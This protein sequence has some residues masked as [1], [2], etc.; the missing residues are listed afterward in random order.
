VLL[1]ISLKQTDI[2]V[3][4]ILICKNHHRVT[5]LTSNDV[6]YGSHESVMLDTSNMV[7]RMAAD[8]TITQLFCA[9]TFSFPKTYQ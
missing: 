2:Y 4:K 1:Y 9:M 5:N 6:Q 8:D 7:I 3:I